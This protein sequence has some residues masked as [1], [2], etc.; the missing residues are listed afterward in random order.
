[1]RAKFVGIV[2]IAIAAVVAQAPAASA[3]AVSPTTVV[4]WQGAHAAGLNTTCSSGSKTMFIV[5][6][7]VPKGHSIVAYDNFKLHL[8]SGKYKYASGNQ[9]NQRRVEFYVVAGRY[10][11]ADLAHPRKSYAYPVELSEGATTTIRIM[12]ACVGVEA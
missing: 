12:R 7:R 3:S 4:Y 2:M 6:M 9:V 11:R 10:A 1:M 5:T 8:K